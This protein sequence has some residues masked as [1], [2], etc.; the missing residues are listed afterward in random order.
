M[1]SQSPNAASE[2]SHLLTRGWQIDSGEV[3]LAKHDLVE[4]HLTVSTIAEHYLRSR[5]DHYSAAAVCGQDSIITGSVSLVSLAIGKINKVLAESDNLQSDIATIA[6]NLNSTTLRAVIRDG[7]LPYVVLRA[8]VDL[9]YE[10]EPGDESGTL[11]KLQDIDEAVLLN[12]KYIRTRTPEENADGAYLLSIEDLGKIFGHVPSDLVTAMTIRRMEPPS[13]GFECLSEK[14][15]RTIRICSS[16]QSYCD[17]FHPL[18]NNIL[19]GLDWSHVFLAGGMALTTLIHPDESEGASPYIQDSDLN[20]YLYD[21]D[22]DQANRKVEEIYNVWKHNLPVSNRKTLVVKNAKTINLIPDYPHRRVQIVLKLFKSPTQVLLGFD[23]DVCAIGFDGSR[24]LMLPRCARAIETGYNVFTMDMIWGH[25]LKSRS[26]SREARIFKYAERGFGLRILP[27]YVRS[28]EHGHATIPVSK[29]DK[30][31][32]TDNSSQDDGSEEARTLPYL[33]APCRRFDSR[34]TYRM[35]D[36]PEAGIKT[37]KRVVYLEGAEPRQLDRSVC[38]L[39]GLN[40]SGSL[41]YLQGLAML[42]VFVRHVEGWRLTVQKDALFDFSVYESP[43]IDRRNYDGSSSYAWDSSFGPKSIGRSL[44]EQSQE[45]FNRLKNAICA[46]LQ[47]PYQDFGYS[48]YLTRR[49]RQQVHG[50]DL[51]SVMEK[52][53]TIPMMVPYDLENFLLNVLPNVSATV[54]APKP[55]LI[56]VHDP[57]L[58]PLRTNAPGVLPHLNDTATEEGNLRYWVITNKSMWAGQNRV[59]DEVFEILWSLFDW[60]R[61]RNDNRVVRNCTE[62]EAVWHMA[63]SIRR[64]AVQPEI[65]QSYGVPSTR[66][67]RIIASNRRVLSPAEMMLFRAWVLAEPICNDRRTFHPPRNF[68]DDAYLYPVPDELFWKDGMEGE[69]SGEYVPQWRYVPV[70]EESQQ[71]SGRRKRKSDDIPMDEDA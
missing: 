57:S 46:K 26:S 47:I 30:A 3:I 66:Y 59:A 4:K 48:G 58:P 60:F 21:L 24:T 41:D 39:D 25:C 31:T 43:M 64:R 62:P 7:R 13:G 28:L 36:G 22:A 55:F 9:P 27:I 34:D 29:I 71:Q 51:K 11:G 23:L 70:D 17:R 19:K 42:E 53:I 45:H 54:S 20:I 6:Q 67:S 2:L 63:E 5:I 35:P 14:R 32:K 56:P 61:R 69:W 52:Q 18:T 8:F 65:P 38:E 1:S 68:E 15:E 49:I 37:L 44:N 33:P 40:N 12:E 50:P 16:S 10:T